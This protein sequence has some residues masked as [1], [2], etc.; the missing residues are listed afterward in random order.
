MSWLKVAIGQNIIKKQ[1]MG[2]LGKR[3]KYL[4][5]FS[6]HPS[7]KILR[8]S[9]EVPTHSVVRFGSTTLS[10]APVQI[11]SVTAIQNCTDKRRMKQLF[12][13]NN[14][15]TPEIIEIIPQ[16]EYDFS[17]PLVAKRSF[18]SRGKGMKL[19]TSREEYTD[20]YQKRS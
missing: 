3:Y 11:N 15:E 6:R 8:D 14:V 12:I 19:L 20:F 4:R 13:E 10:K 9:I 16:L 7:H 1:H 2:K 17:R 5:V 18:R